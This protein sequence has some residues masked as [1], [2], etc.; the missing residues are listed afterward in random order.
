LNGSLN[1]ADEWK[2]L[3]LIPQIH[4]VGGKDTVVPKEVAFAFANRFP[5]SKKPEVLVIPAFNHTCC[6]MSATN[7]LA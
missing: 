2:K 5:A 1:P 3:V 7:M 6:W 4:W